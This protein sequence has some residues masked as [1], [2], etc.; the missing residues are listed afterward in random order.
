MP[1]P[2]HCPAAGLH[3]GAAKGAGSDE[4]SVSTGILVFAALFGSGASWVPRLHLIL[5]FSFS[6]Q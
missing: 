5:H 2:T 1:D 4:M 3:A 6:P